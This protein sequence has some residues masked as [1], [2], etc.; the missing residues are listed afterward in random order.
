VVLILG[1]PLLA[2]IFSYTISNYVISAVRPL[3]PIMQLGISLFQPDNLFLSALFLS[4]VAFPTLLLLC[5]QGW[6]ALS[7]IIPV[8]IALAL[9]SGALWQAARLQP[10]SSL[11]LSILLGAP[12]SGV[13]VGVTQCC[14]YR[15][16]RSH[17]AYRATMVSIILSVGEIVG[18]ACV[19]PEV[20]WNI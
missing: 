19:F 17:R 6:R 18:I 7:Y 15:V 2:G 14:V 13:I 11:D 8:D 12:L 10:P 9:A 20:H 16:M 5:I 3:E 4:G 1:L